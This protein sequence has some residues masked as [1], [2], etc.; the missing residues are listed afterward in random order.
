MNRKRDKFDIFL[1]K[2]LK[3]SKNKHSIEKLDICDSKQVWIPTWP[4]SKSWKYLCEIRRT[5][6][7]H[8]IKVAQRENHKGLLDHVQK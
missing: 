3:M 1:H 2:T 8:H 7:I 6:Q 5:G 4:L